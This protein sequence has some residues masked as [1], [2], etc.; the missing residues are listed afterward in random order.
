M[1]YPSQNAVVDSKRYLF[2]TDRPN[3][4]VKAPPLSS[5]TEETTDTIA[6]GGKVPRGIFDKPSIEAR[7]FTPDTDVPSLVPRQENRTGLGS[8]W[9]LLKWLFVNK[10]SQVPPG[11]P[12]TTTPNN[13]KNSASPTKGRKVDAKRRSFELA[14]RQHLEDGKSTYHPLLQRGFEHFRFATENLAVL[15]DTNKEHLHLVGKAAVG[16]WIGT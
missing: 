16:L 15:I 9:N 14:Y 8:L 6:S 10:Q 4:A 11:T 13:N 5:G 1:G 2:N 3:G 7:T 12:P